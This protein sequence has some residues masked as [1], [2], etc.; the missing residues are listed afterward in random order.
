MEKTRKDG[1]NEPGETENKGG[2][3]PPLPLRG[4]PEGRRVREGAGVRAVPDVVP[5]ELEEDAGAVR[6]EY[7]RQKGEGPG[8]RR[9]AEN[10]SV[11]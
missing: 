9:P 8:G 2:G 5:C 6:Q 11:T 7:G 4:L 1:E 3:V 10:R